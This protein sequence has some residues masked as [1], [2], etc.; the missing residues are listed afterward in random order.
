MNRKN[1]INIVLILIW[2]FVIFS[3]SAEDSKKSTETSDQVIVK[4][5][6]TIKKEVWKN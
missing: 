2:L 6:E 1:Y 3:F 5:A 4:T